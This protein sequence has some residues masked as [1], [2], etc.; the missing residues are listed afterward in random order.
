MSTDA[1][2]PH[3][4]VRF[5]P[6]LIFVAG[7]LLGW[8]LETRVERFRL[9]GGATS[10]APLELFGSAALGAGLGLMLWGIATFRRA[11]TAVLPHRPASRLVLSGPYRFTRNPMYTGLTIGYVGLACIANVGW[12]LVLLPLV[13]ATLVRLVIRREEDYL[14]HA[15]GAEYEA[16]QHRVRRWL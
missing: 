14:V 9:I 13:L 1:R 4:G 7:F 10:A 16:Y 5:P 8:I 12:P 11:R 2:L 6:P 3:P 15:F